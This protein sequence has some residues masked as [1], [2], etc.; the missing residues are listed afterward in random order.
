[1]PKTIALQTANQKLVN[2]LQQQGYTVVD[3]YEAHH[4]REIVDAYLYSTYHPDALTTY[5]S[6]AE[7]EDTP[8]DNTEE[9]SH[10][11][12]LMLNITNLPASQ[13]LA[14]LERRL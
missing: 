5:F 1:M 4:Q 10:S 9:F 12:T 14:T 11:S 7:S 13:I 6:A 8:S 3:M 2:L